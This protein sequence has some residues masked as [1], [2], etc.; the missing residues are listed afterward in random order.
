[1]RNPF[2]VIGVLLA[3]LLI[4]AVLGGAFS[5]PGVTLKNFHRLRPDMTKA[6][7]DAIFGEERA[8]ELKGKGLALLN[9]FRWSW[10]EDGNSAYVEFDPQTGFPIFAIF[11]PPGGG[12]FFWPPPP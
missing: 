1:M 8:S 10:K 12:E 5:R 6:Q 4:A 7:V 3:G 11:K 9:V 2:I